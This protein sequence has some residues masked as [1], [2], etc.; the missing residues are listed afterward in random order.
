MYEPENNN[1][2]TERLNQ[3][4]ENAAESGKTSA[5]VNGAPSGFTGETDRDNGEYHYKNG[6]TQKIYSDAHY[7][8]ADENTVPPRYYTP[9]EK[10]SKEPKPRKKC[11][12]GVKITALCLVCAILGGLCGGAIVGG[13]V[14]AQI[15][16]MN[17]RVA[18][19][20]SEES[21]LT[22]AQTPASGSGSGA[23]VNGSSLAASDIYDI[24][25]QQVVGI[26]SEIT[27]TNF[28]GMSSAAAVSG[29]GFV[30]TADGYILTNYHVI[31][32]AYSSNAEIN[33]MMH[34]GTKYTATVVGFEADNDIAV[35]KID[36]DGLSPATL[37][38]S[39]DMRVGDAVYAVGNPL[40][41]LEFTM[42]SGNVSALDRLITTDSNSEAINMFQ[43]DAP[44]N[45][46]NSGGPVYNRRGEVIGVVT[47]KYSK[48]G[49]EGLSFAV[50]IND[51]GSIANDLI[52]K[53]YVTGKAYMGVTV[54]NDYNSIYANYYGWPL[55]AMVQST[56]A[57]SCAET[58][59]IRSGDIITQIGDK[60]VESYS[61]LR[62]AV[63]NYSAGD[64][65][66]VTL[67]R[68]GE[69]LT[70]SITF[71]EVK[72]DTAS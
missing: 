11:S 5:Q 45:S 50:P 29:S 16:D 61:D 57:G 31:E 25:C 33:V 6:Y 60:T 28:F 26:S 59:G 47:A 51:A 19:I 23:V 22:T 18:A 46:G 8:P 1:E 15:A 37:A 70:L 32:T 40:G 30:I 39:D 66:E 44:V 42:T 56:E 4:A 13:S 49:V 68:A 58:A 35:L 27:Y 52:T 2:K 43:F 10:P 54:R 14:R 62:S 64:T 63:K 9:S 71:D 21:V 17:E 34:D 7:V 12:L 48:S 65:A 20:E 36:A 53:G 69:S 72:P 3:E 67:Y 41:E 38:D 24:A 55:G